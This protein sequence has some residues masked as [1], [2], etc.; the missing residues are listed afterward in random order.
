M[1]AREYYHY[2]FA[3]Y[4]RRMSL[5][6]EIKEKLHEWFHDIA[7]AKHFN[8]IAMN[9]LDA[10]VHMLVEQ[11]T[12][13]SSAYI[14]RS[15]KGGSSYR[16]FLNYPNIDRVVYRKLWARSYCCRKINETGLRNLIEYIHNQT[17]SLGID[18]RFNEIR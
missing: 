5:D 17:D 14:M 18:K 6:R 1:E 8:I 7:S 10:H 2:V 11:K 3:T 9:I 15:I 4:K 13:D 16:L 12:N